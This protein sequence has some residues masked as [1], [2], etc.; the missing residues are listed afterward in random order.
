MVCKPQREAPDSHPEAMNRGTTR[1][2]SRSGRQHL[3][4]RPVDPQPG[5]ARSGGSAEVHGFLASP[6]VATHLASMNVHLCR[7]FI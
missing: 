6:L 2:N 1:R 4:L 7:P 5:A 3:N